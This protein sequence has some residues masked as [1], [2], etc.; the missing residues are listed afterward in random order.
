MKL[1][2]TGVNLTAKK[3]FLAVNRKRLRSGFILS[4]ETTQLTPDRWTLSREKSIFHEERASAE[5]SG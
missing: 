2:L 5:Q 1:C 4:H 3:I